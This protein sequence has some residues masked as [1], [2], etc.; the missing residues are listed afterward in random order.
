MRKTDLT[1]NQRRLIEQVRAQP[2]KRGKWYGEGTRQVV[3]ALLYMTHTGC[4]LNHCQGRATR[5]YCLNR[6]THLRAQRL[7]RQVKVGNLML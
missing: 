6:D 2:T 5:R 1:G 4:Q 3:N 7:A